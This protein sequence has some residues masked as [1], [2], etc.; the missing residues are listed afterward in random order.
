[1]FSSFEH[2]FPS[3]SSPCGSVTDRTAFPHTS[4]STRL[5]R[6]ILVVTILDSPGLVK[7]QATM[8]HFSLFFSFACSRSRPTHYCAVARLSDV[9]FVRISSLTVLLPSQIVLR[10]TASQASLSPPR[11]P[12]ASLRF[13]P[14][15]TPTQV[16]SR[17]LRLSGRA[18]L[19]FYHSFSLI[20]DSPLGFPS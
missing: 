20:L 19:R 14:L 2:R 12:L 11:D 5:V 13:M 4:P 16:P 8:A 6:R 9:A 7:Y 10:L 18:S 1:M 3:S 17:V 15:F